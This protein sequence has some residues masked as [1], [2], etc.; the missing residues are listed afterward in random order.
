MLNLRYG[1]RAQELATALRRRVL[2]RR[3]SNRRSGQPM[4][5]K[6]L[7]VTLT[8]REAL[9]VAHVL[10]ESA[11]ILTGRQVDD[12]MGPSENLMVLPNQR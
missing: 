8:V 6:E 11:R 5:D 4:C 7:S 3:E 1:E 10:H 2:E 12:E 9:E